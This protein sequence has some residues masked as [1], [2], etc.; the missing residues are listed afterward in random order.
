MLALILMVF[1]F[2]FFVIAAIGVPA[3]RFNLIGA[4]LACCVLAYLLPNFS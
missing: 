3:G 1:A 2:V 4:G